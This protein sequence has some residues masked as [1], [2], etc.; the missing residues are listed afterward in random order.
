MVSPVTVTLTE[1]CPADTEVQTIRIEG[2]CVTYHVPPGTEAGSVPSFDDG[3]GLSFIDR[4]VLVASVEQD[5]DL[6][7]C[8]TQAP[9]C[10]PAPEG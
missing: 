4:S 9:P 1:T 3:G 6:V 7:L 8:G 10:A 5:E 2:G